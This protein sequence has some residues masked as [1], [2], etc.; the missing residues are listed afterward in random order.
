MNEEWY[1]YDQY[2]GKLVVEPEEGQP[3]ERYTLVSEGVI[4]RVYT[5]SF[6]LRK[7]PKKAINFAYL[8]EYILNGG[9][10]ILLENHLRKHGLTMGDIVYPP[11][12]ASIPKDRLDMLLE[13]SGIKKGE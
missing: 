8:T 3:R 12:R 7:D 9:V 10:E 1:W 2:E 11:Y 6:R 13:D 5:A 4:D